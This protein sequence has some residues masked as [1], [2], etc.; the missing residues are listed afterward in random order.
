M[1]RVPSIQ[2][3]S[4]GNNLEYS[5]SATIK[6]EHNNDYELLSQPYFLN[7]ITAEGAEALL[8]EKLKK[9]NF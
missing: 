8:K 1:Q 6:I 4:N 3:L 2:D 5:S 9:V 7:E